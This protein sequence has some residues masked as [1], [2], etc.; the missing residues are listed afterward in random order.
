MKH[1]VVH[2]DSLFLR[3]FR[4]EDRHAIAAG[5]QAER[6]RLFADPDTATR[7]ANIGNTARKPVGQVPIEHGAKPQSVCRN[8]NGAQ[9]RSIARSI[10]S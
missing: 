9:S 2:M 10:K 1:I 4:H 7:L 8:T 3:C 6:T 5:L